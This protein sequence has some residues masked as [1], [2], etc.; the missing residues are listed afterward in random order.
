[1]TACVTVELFI[2]ADDA[3]KNTLGAN[4]IQATHN[5]WTVQNFNNTSHQTCHPAIFE[6]IDPLPG[7]D[8]RCYCDDENKK[9]SEGLEQ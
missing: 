5:Y 1:M 9:I 8:K 4:G 3:T 6:T 2:K 7:K